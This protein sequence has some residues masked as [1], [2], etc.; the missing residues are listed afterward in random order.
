MVK[1]T[2]PHESAN[3]SLKNQD[4]GAKMKQLLADIK[5]EAA[6]FSTINGKRGG[7]I[8]VNVDD[9]SQMPTIGEPLFF[10]LNADVEFFPVMLPQDLEK[11]G[12]AIGAALK[13]WG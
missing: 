12:P 2:I 1:F 9:A 3:N 10:W 7:Y 4:F 8:I 11:A 6:Y 5:A 13:K